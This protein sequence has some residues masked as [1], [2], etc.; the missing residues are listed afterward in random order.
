MDETILKPRPGRMGRGIQQA[1][2]VEED[3]AKTV[4]SSNSSSK[5]K[6]RVA[7]S[8]V[9]IFNNLIVEAA[10]DCFSLVA[11]I[12]KSI[13]V[14]DIA[15]LKHKAIEAIKRFEV[16]ARSQQVSNEM[17]N[18]GR[19]CLCALIDESVLNSSWSTMEWADESLLSVFHKETFGGEYFYT[20]LDNA[21]SSPE[22][23]IKF[24]E[25]Q[26]HCLN[27]GFKGKY[28]LAKEGDSKV[29]D[30]RNRLYQTVTQLK[31]PVSNKLSPNWDNR[32]ASGVALREQIPL[33]VVFSI[34]GLLALVIYLIINMQLNT[35]VA[36]T[37]VSLASIHP[38]LVET[39]N[40]KDQQLLVLEQLLQT[41]IQMKIVTVT[42]K[43]DRIRITIN[44]QSLFKPGEANLLTSFQPI[45]A[46]LGRSLE[47]TKGKILITGHTDNTPINTEKYPS[48]WHLSL[49]RAT[50][51]A[52][53]MAK[54]TNL[55]GRLWPEGKGA[56]EPLVSNSDASSRSLNR[57]IEI[58]LLF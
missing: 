55:S 14:S 49:S 32:V 42:Y 18:N 20:L 39:V 44:S 17:L 26:Y 3:P 9:A 34:L 56:A 6:A 12:N 41:E 23:N 25:L 1:K 15:S 35:K 47:G 8:N 30:Y 4:I 45:L 48:N 7:S 46:K 21:L 27:F 19:Y 2:P 58:D 51:V 24:L 16:I 10:S 33:W 31:G 5:P 37:E 43:S 57:R 52:N 28:R 38:I 13:E 11:F 50:Q 36:E 22:Q 29:E 54:N 53:S 40:A